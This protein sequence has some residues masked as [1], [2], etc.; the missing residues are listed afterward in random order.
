MLGEERASQAGGTQR[1]EQSVEKKE[2]GV[3]GAWGGVR[4][5]WGG[6]VLGGRTEM[7]RVR[8]EGWVVKGLACHG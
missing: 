2:L 8:G 7:R 4:Y 6:G 3:L 5:G 1:R